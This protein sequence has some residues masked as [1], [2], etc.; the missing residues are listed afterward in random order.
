MHGRALVLMLQSG[1]LAIKYGMVLAC[2]LH[3]KVR[4]HARSFPEVSSEHQD[5]MH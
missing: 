1:T 4:T 5:R 3:L 2:F